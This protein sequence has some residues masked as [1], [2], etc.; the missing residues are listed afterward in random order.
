MRFIYSLFFLMSTFCFGQQIMKNINIKSNIIT[1][2]VF[3]EALEKDIKSDRVL[4]SFIVNKECEII[5]ISI[6]KVGKL[7]TFNKSVS[8][9][10][11]NIKSEI[12]ENLDCDNLKRKQQNIKM[13]VPIYFKLE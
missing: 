13:F 9:N 10:L 4:I 12:Q 7:D 6:F 5:E 1:G 2:D 8:K 11:D 3:S